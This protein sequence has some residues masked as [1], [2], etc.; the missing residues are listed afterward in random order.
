MTAQTA[1]AG[2]S[3]QYLETARQLLDARRQGRALA[4]FPGPLPQ[5][6]SEAYAIQEVGV[7]L[8]RAP[9]LGWKV[10]RIAGEA[11]QQLKS[12]HLAGPVYAGTVEHAAADPTL[13]S[14]IPGGFCA[15]EAEFIFVLKADAPVGKTD[16]TAP[17]AAD[18]AGALHIGIEIAGSSIADLNAL[19]PRAVIADGGGNSSVILG[20]EIPGWRARDPATLSS[21]TFIDG[22]SVGR[23]SAGA[24]KDGPL[25]SLCFLLAHVAARGRPARA[26]QFVATGQTTGIHAIAAGQ[27]ARASFG[28][29]GAVTCRATDA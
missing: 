3:A 19:G 23:G 17:E 12:D 4:A 22:V 29:F 13:F 8:R 2:E 16:W 5:S 25:G 21:E 24:L 10:G 20:P 28:A 1:T 26:G 18:L 7:E 14:A 6:L 9:I 27:T 11:A 15:I